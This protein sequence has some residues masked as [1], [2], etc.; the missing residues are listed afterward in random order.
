VKL[1]PDRLIPAKH[2]CYYLYGEDRDALFES[3]EALLACPEGEAQTIRADIS[4]IER[5][6]LESKHQG[7]FGA[8]RCH[9]L[10]RNAESANPKQT[11]K[12]L[13]LVDHLP[14][15]T[16][17]VICAAGIES[18]KALH[19][20]MTAQAEVAGCQ[21]ARPTPAQFQTWL[22]EQ[23][24]QSGLKLSADAEM[25]LAENLNGMRQAARQA[26]ERLRL[27]DGG[28]GEQLGMDVV[29]D[30]L[31]ERSPAELADYCRAVASRDNSAVS[32][33][34]RL[35]GDQQVVEVQ[36]L[37]WLQ[38][39]FQSMLLYLWHASENP[40]DAAFRAKLFGDARQQIPQECKHWQP[41]ALMHALALIA[42]AEIKLKGASLEDKPVVIERLTLQLLKAVEEVS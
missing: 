14:A 23:L 32:M 12:L 13:Q 15:E 42:E 38:T 22:R 30:L 24:E 40:R 28:R 10:I 36:V 33:L 41:G 34:H 35:L 3:A 20:K 25:M 26:M 2:A 19:K 31:G 17:L 27:Y 21:F 18:R 1:S 37:S 9:A 8:T 39:R 5:I 7:L 4:E 16:R 29:G 11:N 6:E